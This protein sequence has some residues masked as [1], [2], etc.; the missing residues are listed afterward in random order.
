MIVGEVDDKLYLERGASEQRRLL[1]NTTENNHI[2][3][4]N[5]ITVNHPLTISPFSEYTTNDPDV[6][7]FFT[8]HFS[9]FSAIRMGTPS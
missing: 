5:I 2:S 6:M 8:A 4:N 7:A 3:S 9:F 1:S